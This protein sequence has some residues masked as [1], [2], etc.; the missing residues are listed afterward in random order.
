M[1]ARTLH[2][3]LK[4]KWFD[5][6]LSGKKKEEYREVKD[7]WVNRLSFAHEGSVGGDFYHKHRVVAYTFKTFDTITFKNG[8]SANAPEI[9]VEC[10]G[11]EIKEGNPEWGAEP[12]VKYFVLSVGEILSTK[13]IDS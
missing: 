11:I 6:I 4:K 8:Y 10:K 12:G 5:L 7:Y 2:L 13:N 1:E 9:V 3:T